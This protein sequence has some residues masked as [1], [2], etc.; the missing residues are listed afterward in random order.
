VTY[1]AP[2][3]LAKTVATLDVLSGGRAVLGIGAGWYER[4]HRALG[5]PFPPLRDRFELLEEALQIVRQMWSEDDGPYEGRHHQLA[6]TLC[7]P[8]PVSAPRP[9][10]M[11]GGGGERKTLRMVAQ[12]ADACNL[13]GDVDTVAHKIDVLRAHCDRLGRDFSEIDVTAMYRDIP[14][15]ATTEQVVAGAQRLADLGVT[16][17]YTSVVGD[18]PAAWLEDTFGPAMADIG[19]ISSAAR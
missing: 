11:I 5:V 1:R 19:A 13:M 16:T 4:E 12:Y 6:E 8:Q 2:G 14:A 3:V 17:I 15:G 18:D 9:R 7:R 10:I